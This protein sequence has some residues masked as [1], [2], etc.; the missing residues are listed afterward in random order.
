[1]CEESEKRSDEAVNSKNNDGRDIDQYSPNIKQ[2][3]NGNEQPSKKCD[4]AYTGSGSPDHL[5]NTG[6][7]KPREK[8]TISPK[9]DL[10]R[11]NK[12]LIG[13][14][15]PVIHDGSSQDS[16]ATG[17]DSHSDVFIC[18]GCQKTFSKR[19]DL[20]VHKKT[21][22]D[23]RPLFSCKICQQTFL[24]KKSL[25]GHLKKVH[26]I[27]I[28]DVNA[29]M[30]TEPSQFFEKLQHFV[31]D[32]KGFICRRCGQC[33]TQKSRLANHV[34]MHID[35]DSG[36]ACSQC[37]KKFNNKTVLSRHELNRHG[38][39]RNNHKCGVCDKEFK[40]ESS[41]KVHQAR[42]KNPD[43]RF[44]CPKCD[45]SFAWLNSLKSHELVHD[46]DQ[47]LT[48]RRCDATFT[49]E[50]AFKRH[51][52]TL[53]YTV[54][55]YPCS[56]CDKSFHRKQAWEQHENTHDGIRSFQCLKCEKAYFSQLSLNR[57]VKE[58]HE[59]NK[60]V[61][62]EPHRDQTFKESFKE[63]HEDQSPEESS[64]RQHIAIIQRESLNKQHGDKKHE[65]SAQK[66]Q[67]VKTPKHCSKNLHERE[68]KESSKGQREDKEQ[69]E[70]RTKG[71]RIKKKTEERK[72]KLQKAIGR[73]RFGR[74]FEAQSFKKTSLS[75]CVMIECYFCPLQFSKAEKHKMHEE[76]HLS[77]LNAGC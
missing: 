33:L 27:E 28:S 37:G 76:T 73:L 61:P 13:H 47:P 21:V 18:N 4:A 7:A 55:R 22:C 57:H 9:I 41:L 75:H 2:E 25:K 19:R 68:H 10:D 77:C 11:P 42:H 31:I 6:Q 5:V 60:E 23:S 8:T 63:Q 12:S 49:T 20:K 71:S 34:K 58:Q 16:F 1:M 45:K 30:K 69:K 38:E 50:N 59:E 52:Q 53:C 35:S 54:K 62:N 39:K 67:A 51:N 46:S 65:D 17:P 40:A 74:D 3:E 36:Y 56:R 72:S 44:Q 32:D 64:I 15:T 48:C 43:L 66:Q 26:T 70:R 24:H 14:K 29:C